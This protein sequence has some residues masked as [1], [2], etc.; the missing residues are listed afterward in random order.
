MSFHS[1]IS[2]G[3]EGELLGTGLGEFDLGKS[4][5]LIGPSI[6]DGSIV[7]GDI[8]LA[9]V[10]WSGGLLTVSHRLL[11][12][13]RRP[14]PQM[15]GFELGFGDTD[16]VVL[17]LRCIQFSHV[18]CFVFCVLLCPCEFIFRNSRDLSVSVARPA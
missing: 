5:K 17:G 16:S 13:D 11:A 3:F 9:G 14:L 18:L 7:G 6:C 12:A 10:D 8:L 4:I 15:C 1:S 2:N